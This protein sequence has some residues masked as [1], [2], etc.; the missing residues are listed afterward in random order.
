M[1]NH[2]LTAFYRLTRLKR[3]IPVKSGWP[4]LNRYQN[5]YHGEAS[6]GIQIEV[7]FFSI[8][9]EVK[10]RKKFK[11]GFMTRPEPA[12]LTQGSTSRISKNSGN[13]AKLQSQPMVKRDCSNQVILIQL[14]SSNNAP[15][16]LQ[17]NAYHT[18]ADL[19][20]TSIIFCRN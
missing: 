8:P 20:S 14:F 9:I 10:D 3:W 1:I 18:R 7:L 16:K 15:G 6:C 19:L 17:L 13:S 5:R 11:E 4:H 2:K 12:D